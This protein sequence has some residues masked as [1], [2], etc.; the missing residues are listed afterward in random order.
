MLIFVYILARAIAIITRLKSDTY[1]V[2]LFVLNLVDYWLGRAAVK[3][4]LIV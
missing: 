2:P 1:A 3:S 4:A